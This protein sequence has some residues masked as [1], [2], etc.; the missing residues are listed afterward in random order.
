MEN[1]Q[2]ST[3]LINITILGFALGSDIWNFRILGKRRYHTSIFLRNQ[4]FG[5]NCCH[6]FNGFKAH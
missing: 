1:N 5:T 3:T 6:D 4:F 2:N